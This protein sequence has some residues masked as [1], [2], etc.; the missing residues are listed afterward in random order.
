MNKANKLLQNLKWGFVLMTIIVGVSN[1]NGDPNWGHDVKCELNQIINQQGSKFTFVKII[2]S[3]SINKDYSERLQR[4]TVKVDSLNEELTYSFYRIKEKLKLNIGTSK[5]VL[6]IEYNA[7]KYIVKMAQDVAV[8]F[9][10]YKWRSGEP[11]FCFELKTKECKI[12]FSV[13][14]T[15]DPKNL[16][17]TE[18]DYW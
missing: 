6:I 7:K 9:V 5:R 3:D 14:L 11:E 10:G 13:S 17:I 12:R 4:R 1:T 8:N 15:S 16:W 18:Y 2:N